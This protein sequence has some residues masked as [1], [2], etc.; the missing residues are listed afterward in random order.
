MKTITVSDT[1]RSVGN[2]AFDR[3][4]G[5]TAMDRVEADLNIYRGITELFFSLFKED[6]EEESSAKC[7]KSSISLVAY[8]V[9]QK[10]DND[11][12]IASKYMFN[13]LFTR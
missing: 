11:A 13:N 5:N 7:A 9:K 10:F 12:F 4:S 2:R 3:W 6:S 8:M 1:V